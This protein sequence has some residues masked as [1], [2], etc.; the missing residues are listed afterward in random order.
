MHPARNSDYMLKEGMLKLFLLYCV[1]NCR[2]HLK[3]WVILTLIYALLLRGSQK[4]LMFVVN[5]S[6]DRMSDCQIT[7]TVYTEV[8]FIESNS[9]VFISLLTT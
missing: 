1:D 2:F 9:Y 4:W 5:V 3:R 8:M 7:S 6:P